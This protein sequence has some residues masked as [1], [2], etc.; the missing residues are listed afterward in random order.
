M[1]AEDEADVILEAAATPEELDA[2]VSR[3][4][5]GLPLEQ[6]VGWAQFLDLRIVV[7]PGVFV[8]RR[9]T[10]AV[11]TEALRLAGAHPVVLDLCCGSGALATVLAARLRDAEV[12][13]A[14]LHPAAVRCARRNLAAYGGHVVE[15]DLFEPLPHTLRGRVDVMVV[16]AP[17]VPTGAIALMP[18]EARDHEPR[19]TLDGGV[20]GLVLHRRIACQVGAWLGP[21]GRVLIETS[22]SQAEATSAALSDAGLDVR[23]VRDDDRDGTVA[24]GTLTRR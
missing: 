1:F 24:V 19:V 17:Y 22:T 4:V 8:P 12:W 3:R 5:A 14:D 10:E 11:A 13:A 6:V 2:M 9:R 21:G 16:N 23:V 15:G 7:E 20:D 18:P